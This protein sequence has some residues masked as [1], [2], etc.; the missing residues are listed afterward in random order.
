MPCTVR[1]I[2]SADFLLTIDVED[3]FQVENFKPWIPYS[4]WETRELRVEQNVHRLLDLFDSI[5]S[6]SAEMTSKVKATFF[7][8]GWIAQRLPHLVREIQARGHEVASHGFGHRL[9]TDMSVDELK[10]DL[11]KSKK[12]LEDISG[13]QVDGYRAPSFAVDDGILEEIQSAGYGYDSSYNSFDM[14]GR[15]GRITLEEAHKKGS[16]YRLC[17]SFFEI[18]VSN[19]NLLGR[20]LPVGGGGYFRLLPFFAFRHAVGSLLK[21]NEAYVFYCHPWEFDPDQ[22]RVNSAGLIPRFKHY[23]NLHRTYDRLKRLIGIFS[24][25]RFIS[26]SEY[27]GELKNRL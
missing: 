26:C 19:L 10:E 1:H 15:Y 17:R 27:V 6:N 13:L 21:K 12:L 2:P 18:P 3:W 14:H 25:C 7:I 16:A 11:K 20:V 22:P 4:T 23:V 8:L 9:C 24:F 5:R